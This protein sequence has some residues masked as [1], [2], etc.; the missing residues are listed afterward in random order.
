MF[1][2]NSFNQYVLSSYV[3]LVALLDSED[4]SMKNRQGLQGD[5][6]FCPSA[7]HTLR[8]SGRIS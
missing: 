6:N 4:I 8:A 3:D 2:T 5:S 1:P 7:S